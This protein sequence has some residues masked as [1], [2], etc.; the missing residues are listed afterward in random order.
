VTRRLFLLVAF[1]FVAAA[2]LFVPLPMPATYAGRTI[3]NSEHTPLFLVGTLFILQIL[4]HDFRIEGARL[5]V[6]SGLIAAGAGLLSE[7]IQR[8]L[9][10]DASWEDVFSDC[11]GVLLA[12]ALH[13]LFDRRRSLGA[14]PRAAVLLIA[15]GCLVT[16]AMPIVSMVRAYLHRDAQFPMLVNFDSR[17][18]LFWMY[19][20]GLKREVRDGALDIVFDA[21]EYPGVS[22]F[23]PVSDWRKYHQL[24]LDVENPGDEVLRFGVRVHDK[25]RGREFTDRFNRR[26]EIGAGQRRQLAIPLDDIRRGPRNRLMDM[27]QITNVTVFRLHGAGSTRMRLYTMRL[28]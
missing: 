4:R 18:E 10:R 28:D 5:Y 12:L 19:S 11:V 21:N 9:R 16:Y 6:L 2:L 15:A 24:I 8:P 23:E 25:G 17:L 26:L 20:Y 1:V 13:A 27:A 22:F 7:V 3:E 14:A